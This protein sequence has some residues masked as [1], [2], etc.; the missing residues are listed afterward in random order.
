MRTSLVVA[1]TVCALAIAV[2]SARVRA[3]DQKP[4]CDYPL[5]E[6]PEYNKDGLYA[7]VTFDVFNAARPS[8]G[9]LVRIN[10]ID[11]QLRTDGGDYTSLYCRGI[12]ETSSRC[13]SATILVPVK[14]DVE[15][16]RAEVKRW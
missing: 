6:A 16:W 7:C 8:F 10:A 3:D 14:E 5:A 2:N 13:A 11:V 9:M 12:E 4:S 1:V 15:I